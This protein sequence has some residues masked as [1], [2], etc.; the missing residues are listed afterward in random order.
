MSDKEARLLAKIAKLAARRAYHVWK[1][2]DID[3]QIN[4]ETKKLAAERGII[5]LR[6]DAIM[7]ELKGL[8]A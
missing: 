4:E 7:Q 2:G 8:K 3:R 1:L 5:F 6:P